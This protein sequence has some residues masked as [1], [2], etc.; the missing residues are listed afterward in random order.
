[1]V[2]II[3]NNQGIQYT[4]YNIDYNRNKHIRLIQNG[5]KKTYKQIETYDI[6][7]SDIA[8]CAEIEPQT[9]EHI[10]KYTKYKLELINNIKNEY[11]NNKL[12]KI[13]E[14]RWMLK[15]FVRLY[16]QKFNITIDELYNNTITDENLK[17]L[18]EKYLLPLL[19]YNEP[20]NNDTDYI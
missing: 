12:I 2:V 19:L 20:D 7:I 11:K 6:V 17:E 18:H 10:Q 4:Y 8:L 9:K 14:V 16:K 13:K 1:M 15:Y 3:N 5:K